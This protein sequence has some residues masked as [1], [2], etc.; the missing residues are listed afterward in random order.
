MKI[1]GITQN[2]YSNRP[3]VKRTSFKSAVSV[4]PTVYTEE[5]LRSKASPTVIVRHLKS[6]IEDG[7]LERFMVT[8]HIKEHKMF[9]VPDYYTYVGEDGYT[10]VKPHLYINM[11]QVKREFLR[12][13]VCKEIEQKIVELS[14]QMGYEGRVLL[15]STCIQGTQDMIPSPTIAHYKNGFRFYNEAM[16]N[17]VE[18]IIRGE[19]PVESTPHGTMYYPLDSLK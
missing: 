2:Y 15:T 3:I 17:L 7:R 5:F 12:Q 8:N 16:N 4:K 11:I 13:G 19:V 6:G 1:L 14:K 9:P 10:Y 18:K